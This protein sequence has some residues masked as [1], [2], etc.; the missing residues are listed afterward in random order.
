MGG[1][2][3][4]PDR[5]RI[6]TRSTIGGVVTS[7][8]IIVIVTVPLCAVVVAT[9]SR[10]LSAS[11]GVVVPSCAVVVVAVPLFASFIVLLHAIGGAWCACFVR[12]ASGACVQRLGRWAH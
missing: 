6:I 4:P 1:I 3:S 10:H 2:S 8:C 12:L 7:P 5:G 11:V 9:P